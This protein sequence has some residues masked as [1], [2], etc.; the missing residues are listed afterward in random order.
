[1]QAGK[2]VYLTGP[3]DTQATCYSGGEF[4][5][6]VAAQI[7]AIT[8]TPSFLGGR[9]EA[10]ENPRPEGRGSKSYLGGLEPVDSYENVYSPNLGEDVVPSAHLTVVTPME[11]SSAIS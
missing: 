9:D 6:G 11:P 7:G 1:M 3:G 4:C 10:K 8:D 5:S 2:Q